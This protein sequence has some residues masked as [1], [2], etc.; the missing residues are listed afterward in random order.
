MSHYAGWLVYDHQVFV[1]VDNIK[2]DILRF[3]RGRLRG[4]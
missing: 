2:L 1:L 3:C 4:R